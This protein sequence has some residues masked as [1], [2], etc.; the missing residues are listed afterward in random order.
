[1]EFIQT[2]IRDKVATITLNRGKVNPINEKM[3]EEL[4]AAFGE[5]AEDP[6]VKTIILNAANTFFSFGLDIP[7]FVTYSKPEFIRF[8]TK[9]ADLY[10]YIFAV[11]KPVIAALHGHTIAGGCMLASACD[12]RIMVSGKPRISLNEITFGSSLFP[13]SVVML[14][15]CVGTRNAEIMSITGQ[16][17]SAEEAKAMGLVDQIV[18]P[19]T[20]Q[21]SAFNLASM[22]AG[23]DGKAFASI[24]RQL[25]MDTHKEMMDKD[26]R[27]RDEMVDIWYSPETWARLQEI[28]IRG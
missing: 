22:F 17:F 10:T 9:F 13:G 11:P 15:Y 21:D 6:Q 23:L 18:S 25:R 1:M 14:R 20:I 5:Y 19:E 4:R 8:V 2:G 3:T 16:M 27:Y 26:H 7:E 28:K 12:C 24:K